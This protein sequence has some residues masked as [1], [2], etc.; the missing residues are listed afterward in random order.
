MHEFRSKQ[1]EKHMTT[2][3]GLPITNSLHIGLLVHPQRTYSFTPQLPEQPL[4]LGLR[5]W[6]MV[7]SVP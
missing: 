6:S 3:D 4:G 2:D 1:D 5:L 7:S